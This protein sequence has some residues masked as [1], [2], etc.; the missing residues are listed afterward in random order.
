MQKIT[1]VLALTFRRVENGLQFLLL[2]HRQ[3]F[4]TFPGGVKEET[5][6]TLVECLR[7]EIK[8]ETGLDVSE[9][10]CKDTGVKNEF[11]YGLEKPGRV[12]GKGIT[13]LFTL[14]L[15]E[16]EIPIPLENIEEVVWCDRDE[17]LRRV[18]LED[19][20]QIFLRVENKIPR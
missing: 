20:K 2:K 3:G 5:D 9:N 1:G 16:N 4:W 17:V 12:G 18:R 13:H 7:R 8:E 10:R 15:G 6:G 14:E 19:I 11:V